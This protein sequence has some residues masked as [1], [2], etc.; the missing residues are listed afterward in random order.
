[1]RK[2]LLAIDSNSRSTTWH[3]IKTKSRG[4]ALEEFLTY[5]QLHIIMRIMQEQTLKAAEDQATLT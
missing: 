2:L 1:M 5:N 3:D 4:K